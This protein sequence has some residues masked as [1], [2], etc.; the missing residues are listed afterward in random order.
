MSA[1]MPVSSWRWQDGR[2]GVECVVRTEQSPPPRAECGEK[3]FLPRAALRG[4]ARAAGSA[5]QGRSAWFPNKP[6]AN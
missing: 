4:P 5:V 2:A 3:A 1:L 6:T